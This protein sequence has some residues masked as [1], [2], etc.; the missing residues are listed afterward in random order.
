MTGSAAPFGTH[1]D[2]IITDHCHI[3]A[4]IARII[5]T[6]VMMVRAQLLRHA[7]SHLGASR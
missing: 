6:V 1:V 4:I 2:T 3:I 7:R 5:A